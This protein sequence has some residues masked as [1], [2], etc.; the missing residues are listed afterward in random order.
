MLTIEEKKK[1]ED[2]LINL[3]INP[4]INFPYYLNKISDNAENIV[5]LESKIQSIYHKQQLIEQKLNYI[6]RLIE[7]IN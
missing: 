5:T 6:I 3:N 2:I 1:I 7:K 4:K